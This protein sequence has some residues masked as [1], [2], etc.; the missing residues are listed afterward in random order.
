MNK[1][2]LHMFLTVGIYVLLAIL[3]FNSF[4]VF[5]F[6]KSLDAKIDEAKELARPA[7]IEII[8]LESSCSNCFD[9][10]SI[11]E[12]LKKS[13]IEIVNEKSLPRNSKATK[14]IIDNYGIE[15]LPTILLKG[16]IDKPS[17]QN[18]K[19][20]S[21]A[22]VFDAVSPPYED[23]ATKKVIGKV[24]SIAISDKSCRVCTNFSSAPQNLKQSG[25]FIDE[26]EKL[27]F[28]E[29]KAKELIDKFAVKK[30]P[31]VL[32]SDDID[33]YP[34]IAQGINQAGSKKNGYYVIESQA[35]YIEIG[36]GKIR[37]LAKLTLLNDSS[38]S[39]C[40]NIKIHKSILAGFGIAIDKENEININS[41]EGKQLIGKYNIKNVPTIVLTGDLEVYENFDNV[42]KQV[43][44]V[45]TDGAYI[46]REISAMG[47]GIVYKDIST[48]EIKGLDP[49]PETNQQ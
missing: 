21:D 47:T 1:N 48:N 27:D 38:C 6:G 37:G 29:T 3:L 15:K 4:F 7:K 30:L 35:P 11:I 45:E 49:V 20:V 14:E 31:V 12:I 32:L 9:I 33:A 44:T 13:N 23:A 42:W 5:S 39:M 25:V 40:Y 34:E 10:D 8:K 24:S 26:E 16:E 19:K 2:S 41:I 46:F 36:S 28:S 17:I 43:G 18:F 22:L